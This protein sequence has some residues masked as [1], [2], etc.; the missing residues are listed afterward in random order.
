[1]FNI[2]RM[3]R[4][5]LLVICRRTTG[6]TDRG[7]TTPTGR[8]TGRT[9][10]QRRRTTTTGH[11]GTRRD[12]RRGH[13]IHIDVYPSKSTRTDISGLANK[14]VN[15][16][17]SFC[18]NYYFRLYSICYIYKYK[19]CYIY[20]VIYITQLCLHISQTYFTNIFHFL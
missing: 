9:D 17:T 14:S 19:K 12:G 15:R 4:D 8:T 18:K 2:R 5:V 3:L 11:D 6:R 10:G 16:C 1:M 13:P 20:I 7:R